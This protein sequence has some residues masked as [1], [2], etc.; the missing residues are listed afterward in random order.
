[1]VQRFVFKASGS[2]IGSLNTSKSAVWKVTCLRDAGSTVSF[3]ESP[4]GCTSG[5]DF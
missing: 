4:H 5:H 3:L 2:R 1:M